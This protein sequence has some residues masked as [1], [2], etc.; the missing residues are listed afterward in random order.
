MLDDY[1]PI[2]EKAGLM[3]LWNYLQNAWLFWQQEDYAAV[4]AAIKPADSLPQ[5]DILAL[6]EQV[7]YG[8]AL[9]AQKQWAAA[10]DHWQRLLKSAKPGAEQ[11][12]LQM[13]LAA[14]LVEN[15]ETAAIFA[16]ESLVTG[17]RYRSLVLKTKASPEL[18][19]AEA[20]HGMN[21]E[22]RTIALHTLLTRHLIAGRYQDY[23]NDKAL[24]KDLRPLDEKTFGDVNLEI[25]NWKGDD[26]AE[27]YAC[28]T[29]DDTAKRWRAALMTA[30]R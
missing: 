15:N 6:S 11:Q 22:E 10:R 23:L 24:A 27:G 5:H 17:L 28:P 12:L 14:A 19:K 30:M 8:D 18:L 25:F 2:Y 26:V 13:K 3:P 9:G 7:L 20:Q 4:T 21:N 16:P 29:L 1:K